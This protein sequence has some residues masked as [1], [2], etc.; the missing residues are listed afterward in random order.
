[1]RTSGIYFLALAYFM[2]GCSEETSESQELIKDFPNIDA[3]YSILVKNNDLLSLI[4]LNADAE[5]IFLDAGV[6]TFESISNPLISNRDNNEISIYSSQPDC[7]GRISLYNF[8][9]DVLQKTVVFNDLG[10]CDLKAKALAHSWNSLYVAYEVPGTGAEETLYYIRIIDT[11]AL[12]PDFIDIELGKSPLQVVFS[13]NHL[14]IL[15]EDLADNNKNALIV[16][17]TRIKELVTEINLGFEVQRL[18]KSD[19]GNLIVSYEDYHTHIN[20]ISMA[21]TKTVRYDN[22]KEPGFG[23]SESPYY[24][25]KGNLYYA[26]PTNLSGTSY[27]NIPAVYD[28]ETNTAILYYY[29]NFLSEQEQLFEYEIGNTSM[30]SYDNKNDLIV[31]GYQKSG[32]PGRGGLLR[33]RPIPNPAFIDNIDLNGVPFE[34]FTE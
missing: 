11:S 9:N 14:F 31:I 15:S 16:L 30:V 28:F 13:N 29:E 6:N 1:M 20:S 3:N 5:T 2:F 34:M 17:D 26:M 4:N 27:P 32:D 23:A 10:K 21:I 8:K 22:G 7:S 25:D 12:E 19:E 24:D 33:I 18:F